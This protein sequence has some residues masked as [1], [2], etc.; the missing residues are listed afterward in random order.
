MKKLKTI[1]LN[2]NALTEFKDVHTNMTPKVR[3][4]DLGNNQFFTKSNDDP[5]AEAT[6]I[7]KLKEFN[8]KRLVLQGNPFIG[9]KPDVK[10]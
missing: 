9:D 2:S 1:D 7:A 3:N 8:L 4:L 6:L 10:K 5:N